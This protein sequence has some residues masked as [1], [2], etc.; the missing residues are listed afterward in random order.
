MTIHWDS[1][2]T[3]Y[4]PEA[5]G[6]ATVSGKLWRWEFHRYLGPTFLRKDGEPRA[7]QNPP[8]AVW[9]AFERWLK[10]QDKKGNKK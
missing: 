5:Y 1:K 9:T 7:N 4:V 6:Q 10:R 8:K 2:T 3:L